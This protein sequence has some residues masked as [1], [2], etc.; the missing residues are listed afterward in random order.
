MR[1]VSIVCGVALLLIAGGVILRFGGGEIQPAPGVSQ[2]GKNTEGEFVANPFGVTKGADAPKLEVSE[3]EFDF[4]IMKFPLIDGDDPGTNGDGDS[5][6]FVIKNVGQG[7]LKLAKGPSTCQCTMSDLSGDIVEVPPGG[8]TKVTVTWEP[9]ETADP[10]EKGA[11]IWTNDPALFAADSEFKDG[12]IQLTVKG[13]VLNAVDLDPGYFTLGTISEKTPTVFEGCVFSRASADLQV[14]LKESSSEFLTAEI[15]PA[16]AEQLTKYS[17]LSGWAFKGQLVPKLPIG[18]FNGA[19][20][21]STNDV[22]TPEVTLTIGAQRKGPVSI[23]GRFWNDAYSM[24]D[25]K[26]F[27]AAKGAETTLSLYVGK[28]EPPI[29]LTIAEVQPDGLVVT[30]E[31]DSAYADPERERFMVKVRV[32][33]GR[34]PERL[35]GQ[36]AGFV[37]LE[38]NIVDVPAIKFHI[39]Y[40]SR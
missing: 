8:S 33:E 27:E 35:V 32:P 30:T 17:A 40:E 21:F 39:V 38:T 4:G 11:T 14:Q 22:H 36:E 1:A 12:K 31:R 23:A 34:A 19:L 15:T 24:I 37:R 13:R 28:Q 2:D 18:R 9:K 20:K 29:E 16:T 5:H 6:T 3:K 26:K 10:F 7:V 25:F